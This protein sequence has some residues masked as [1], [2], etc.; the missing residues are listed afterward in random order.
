MKYYILSILIASLLFL[1]TS[2]TESGQEQQHTYKAQL[3]RLAGKKEFFCS[4]IVC[5]NGKSVRL[6]SCTFDTGCAGLYLNYSDYQRF[7]KSGLITEHDYVGLVNNKSIVNGVIT[8]K[9][10][11]M[12]SVQ[13]GNVLLSN[14]IVTYGVGTPCK[15]NNMRL[16]GMDVLNRFDSFTIDIKN[17]SLYLYKQ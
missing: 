16:V 7:K 6:D 12:Q 13:L 9:R 11:R 1:T 14:V 2:F 8:N 5:N 3:Y 4:I 15:G 10:Y 17:K